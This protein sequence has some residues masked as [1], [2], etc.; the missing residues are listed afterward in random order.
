MARYRF[1]RTARFLAFF[2][3]CA[4]TLPDPSLALRP[5]GLEEQEMGGR[6]VNNKERLLAALSV[7]PS[8]VPAAQPLPSSPIPS[9]AGAEEVVPGMG[10]P[11]NKSL[12]FRLKMVENLQTMVGA[13]SAQDL[14]NLQR[15]MEGNV[16]LDDAAASLFAATRE[17]RFKDPI[18]VFKDEGQ[19][20]RFLVTFWVGSR[21]VDPSD[22]KQAGIQLFTSIGRYV[23]GLDRRSESHEA[24]QKLY[25]N[26]PVEKIDEVLS[27]VDRLLERSAAGAEEYFVDLLRD[28]GGIKLVSVKGDKRFYRSEDDVVMFV[29]DGENLVIGMGEYPSHSLRIRDDRSQGPRVFRLIG[30]EYAELREIPPIEWMDSQ[31]DV[32]LI[33]NIHYKV[34][35]PD[36]AMLVITLDH[37]AERV[38][39][40]QMGVRAGDFPHNQWIFDGTGT[41]ILR[42]AEQS[43]P[44]HKHT[45]F[46]TIKLQKLLPTTLTESTPP[47]GLEEIPGLA[48]ELQ[49]FSGRALAAPAREEGVT[50][51]LDL[52]LPAG[53]LL[54]PYLPADAIAI[55]RSRE[56]LLA[57]I[58]AAPGQRIPMKEI[59]ERTVF[60]EDYGPDFDRAF[61]LAVQEITRR[62]ETQGRRVRLVSEL[63]EVLNIL[64][65]DDQARLDFKRL[66]QRSQDNWAALS[67][68]L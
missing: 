40:F 6:P 20:R 7:S 47:V 14:A 57:G 51:L 25:A 19:A 39:E 56:D 67:A 17:K 44:Q 9:S 32:P 24:L 15:F 10:I 62:F 58:Q 55:A 35:A 53:G 13:V 52:T 29:T 18:T 49:E 59:L 28:A 46:V 23:N 4:L 2:L 26:R 63:D 48:G 21:H 31:A 5:A 66:F 27:E 61:S 60:L 37:R 64:W 65:L 34:T 16:S 68:Y 3:S 43:P 33:R 8:A 12:A 22:D 36:E 1:K 30:R 41:P 54:L 42:D 50:V 11:P 38:P 45:K